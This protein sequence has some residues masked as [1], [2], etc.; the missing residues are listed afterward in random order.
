MLKQTLAELQDNFGAAENVRFE[1]IAEG[2]PI[3]VIDNSQATARIALHGAHV[4]DWSPKGEKSAIY[5]SPDAIYRE[6]KAIRGGIPVC[7]PW[8]NAHPNDSSKP[9]HGFMRNRFWELSEITESAEATIVVFTL[10]HSEETLE[11]WPHEFTARLSVTISKELR[12]ELSFTN[13]GSEPCVFGGALH[14]YLTVDDVRT[15]EITGLD[16]ASYLNTV[17]GHSADVQ[18]GDVLFDQELDRIYESS[19][20]ISLRSM[21]CEKSIEIGKA[22]SKSTVVW[23]PW[24][25][26]S[27][28]MG[29]LPDDAYLSFICIEA[30][31]AHK[32]LVSIQQGE[33]H[34]LSTTINL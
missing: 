26:K 29:D 23:N 9:A 28:S 16:G 4:M 20:T 30:A 25:E 34:I 2:Y 8:F 18:M 5:L 15:S 12:V 32:D 1:N 14:T 22:G 6:G 7:A 19:S 13:E 24:I 31:N 21:A 3:L 33:T 27:K 17:G 11:L 10:Q